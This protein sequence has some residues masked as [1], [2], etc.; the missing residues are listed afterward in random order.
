LPFAVYTGYLM[1]GTSRLL[2]DVNQ[3]ALIG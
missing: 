1:N 2:W 3:I